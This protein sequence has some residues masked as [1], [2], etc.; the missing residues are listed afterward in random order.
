LVTLWRRDSRALQRRL[1]R[2]LEVIVKI[3]RFITPSIVA[4]VVVLS[5]GGWLVYRERTC[6]RLSKSMSGDVQLKRGAVG[7]CYVCRDEGWL[8]D[9]AY[10]R[11]G[12]ADRAYGSG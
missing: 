6:D 8:Y 5:A 10:R 11:C 4:A 2:R 3:N 7:Q 1:N 12:V 9:I